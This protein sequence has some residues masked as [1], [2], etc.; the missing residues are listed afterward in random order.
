M[1]SKELRYADRLFQQGDAYLHGGNVG[2]FEMHKWERIYKFATS[3][4]GY[5]QDD[6]A[7][8][9]Y[10]TSEYSVLNNPYYFSEPFSGLV[11]PDAHNF[12]AHLMSNR[13]E[14]HKGGLLHGDVL[15]SFFA[16]SGTPGNFKHHEG[17][18]RIPYEWYKR[19]SS[20]PMD[21]V[22]TNV[23]TVINSQM[24]PGVIRFG[25][26]TGKTNSFAGID[27]KD[28]TGGVYNGQNIFTGNNLACF[29]YQASQAGLTDASSPL[30]ESAA[31]IKAFIQKNLAPQLAALNCPQLKDFNNGLFKKY[32]GASYTGQS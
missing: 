29:F 2:V 10:Y 13:S 14:A 25:G 16:V 27:L 30:V 8:Q 21:A 31:K 12:V 19:P 22:D 26:N 4:S 32:P 24:Y 1:R 5:T 9:A 23:D 28:L 11:A 6:A 20:Q 17:Q 3:D 15:K 7:N 18:E